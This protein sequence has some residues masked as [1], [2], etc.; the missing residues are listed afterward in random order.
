MGY[1]KKSTKKTIKKKERKPG[2]GCPKFKP[3]FVEMAR[4]ATE[5]GF[6]IENLAEL[7]KVDSATIYRWEQKHPEFYETILNAR[8]KFDTENVVVA[9]RERATGYKHEETLFFSSNGVVTDERTVIKQYPPDTTAAIFWLKN[10]DRTRWKDFK[11]V[12]LTGKDGAPMEYKIINKDMPPA[13][14]SKLYIDQI[15]NDE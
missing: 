8:D 4:V 2:S 15:K 14:A 13:E 7:F 10:R 1:I 5:K 3:E 6:T 11:A 12:E 9:L